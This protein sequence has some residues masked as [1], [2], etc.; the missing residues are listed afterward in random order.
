[1]SPHRS[2]SST[3][4]T[5]SSRF[6]VTGPAPPGTSPSWPR[7]P[8]RLP[9]PSTSASPIS[10]AQVD[11][12]EGLLT[13]ELAAA[14]PPHDSVVV[15][16][17]HGLVLRPRHEAAARSRLRGDRDRAA[18]RR[19]RLRDGRCGDLPGLVRDDPRR[20]RPDRYPGGRREARGADGARLRPDRPDP[21]PRHPADFVSA[22]RGRAG[23][24]RTDLR[25]R[26]DGRLGRHP[27]P[28]ARATTTC[29]AC[30]ATPGCRDLRRRSGVR[31]ARLL[32]SRC[33]LTVS[34]GA[35]VA[36]GNAPT[37]LF[38]LL[39]MIDG[40]R[41][42]GRPR[43]SASRS[44]SSAPRSRRRRWRRTGP[45]CRTS[46]SAAVVAG[47]RWPPPRST[48]WRTGGASCDAAG[49]TASGSVPATPS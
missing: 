13:P 38:H 3:S 39:E 40:G 17:W 12:P 48:H 27:R 19:L 44:G 30:C 1:M 36:I 8:W 33:G 11:V 20:D 32:P 6:A 21:R 25:R 2:A 4:R 5:A 10:P 35:V 47:P 15:T 37:A 45:R 16:P 46:W 22:G 28:A 31:P 26:G 24:G 14:L 18:A 49:C 43:S 23:G 42:L 34:T 7:G 9:T 41:V 29:C